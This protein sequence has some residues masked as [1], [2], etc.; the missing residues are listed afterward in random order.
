MPRRKSP[1]DPTEKLRVLSIGESSTGPRKEI[2]SGARSM[3]RTRSGAGVSSADPEPEH[4][5]SESPDPD[6]GTSDDESEEELAGGE[7]DIASLATLPGGVYNY[8]HM[9]LGTEEQARRAFDADELSISH[10]RSWEFDDVTYFNFS[11]REQIG[12]YIGPP[13]SSRGP[14][15]CTCGQPSPCKHVWWLEHQLVQARNPE[16]QWSFVNDG[17]TIS[18]IPLYQWILQ[19]GIERLSA[20]GDWPLVPEAAEP[21]DDFSVR[22]DGELRDMLAPFVPSPRDE[23]CYR[24]AY[25]ALDQAVRE[26]AE[27]DRGIFERFRNA[28]HPDLCAQ[29]RFDRDNRTKIN[30]AFAALDLYS[31]IGPPTDASPG[32]PV[33]GC[34]DVLD[35]AVQDLRSWLRASSEAPFVRLALAILLHLIH[36]VV[37]RNTDIYVG[38]PWAAQVAAPTDQRDRNLYVRLVRTPPPSSQL[39]LIDLLRQFPGEAL[40]ERRDGIVQIMDQIRRNG[41]PDR[42][43]AALRDLIAPRTTSAGRK[44]GGDAGEGSSTPKRG[45]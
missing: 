23:T 43:H 14:A 27:S 33:A 8:E 11:L 16:R 34:A 40:Q 41:G 22:R 6:S 15:A 31:R 44:R 25:D 12:I 37:T 20:S 5:E 45:R 24:E 30:H 1:L 26:V 35:S 19:N 28:L 17:S 4:H 2:R 39:F 36:G 29:V 9:D 38:K 18:G 42:Y 3:V 13:N 21:G 7:A 32:A 10:C